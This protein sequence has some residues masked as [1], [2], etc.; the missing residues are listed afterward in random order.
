MTDS[1][2]RHATL[3]DEKVPSQERTLFRLGQEA[4]SLIGAGGITTQHTLQTMT[5]HIL[6]NPPVV[7]RLTAELKQAM[8]DPNIPASLQQLQH[9]PYLSAVISEGLRLSYGISHRMERSY[10]DRA[11]KYGDYVLPPNTSVSMTTMLIHDDPSIF[12][13]PRKFIPERWLDSEQ[14]QDSL[15][16]PISNDNAYNDGGEKPLQQEQSQQQRLAK[17]L[18]P[19]GRGSRVCVGL[20]LAYA[21]LYLALANIF[22]KFELELYDVVRERDVDVSHDFFNPSPALESVGVRVRVVGRVA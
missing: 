3:L 9:L 14:D 21:E 20:N 11:F 12:P 6:A 4:I 8:P 16:T 15:P 13:E 18:L 22:R 5:Y 19:F 10:P 7:A 2:R 1:P 17:Y